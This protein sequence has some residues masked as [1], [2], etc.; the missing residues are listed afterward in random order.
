MENERKLL[1][2]SAKYQER[3]RRREQIAA[4]NETRQG[5]SSKAEHGLATNNPEAT[6]FVGRLTQE[7]TELQL[8]TFFSQYAPVVQTI[9][10]RDGQ[11]VS[12][13]YGFVEFSSKR[14]ASVAWEKA[15]GQVLGKCQLLVDWERARTDQQFKPA[16]LG[17]PLGHL[18]RLPKKRKI[19]LPPMPPSG[20]ID[21][22]LKE[23]KKQ[24]QKDAQ[25]KKAKIGRAHV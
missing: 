8:Q 5:L 6:L 25:K 1:I 2:K 20:P 16:R 9:V 3:V 19:V 24:Q 12:Q 18:T 7:V 15:D 11:C 17:G 22:A 10:V 23:Q 21:K 4:W 13:G 14:E